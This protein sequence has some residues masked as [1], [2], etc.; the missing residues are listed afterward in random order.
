MIKKLDYTLNIRSQEKILDENSNYIWE[1]DSYGCEGEFLPTPSTEELSPLEYI[2]K[3]IPPSVNTQI[4]NSEK[5]LDR[6]FMQNQTK[7][8]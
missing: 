4:L 8:D 7:D 5:V 1:E 3:N 2:N 6:I